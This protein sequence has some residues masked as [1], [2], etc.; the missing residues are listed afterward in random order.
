LNHYPYKKW[1][2]L[3]LSPNQITRFHNLSLNSLNLNTKLAMKTHWRSKIYI[4]DQLRWIRKI[5]LLCNSKIM[6]KLKGRKIKASFTWKTTTKLSK[7][8]INAI[9]MRNNHNVNNTIIFPHNFIIKSANTTNK[10]VNTKN[11]K[12]YR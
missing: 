11:R 7:M 12:M 3:D 1:R 2:N 6:N 8:R 9:C 10:L 5:K 4:I